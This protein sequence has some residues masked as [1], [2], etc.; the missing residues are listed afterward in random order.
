MSNAE[1]TK[2]V[3]CIRELFGGAITAELP[4]SYLDASNIRDIPDNQECYMDP[5]S[6][7]TIIIEIVEYQ[8]SQKDERA[9]LY[10]FEDL[11]ECNEVSKAEVLSYGIIEDPAFMPDMRET[12]PKC[13]LVGEQTIHL[14]DR[15]ADE[16]VY[17]MLAVVRLK[18]VN[19]ELLVNYYIMLLLI[20]CVGTFLYLEVLKTTLSV[21]DT[22]KFRLSLSFSRYQLF[23]FGSER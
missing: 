20:F 15:L 16:K 23:S 8:E 21:V 13:V 14:K 22:L 1:V 17:V 11:C 18:I 2:K 12:F 5:N 6:K 10:F 3:G 19:A 9:S 7:S 4:D